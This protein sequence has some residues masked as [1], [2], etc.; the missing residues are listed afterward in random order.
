MFTNL[1]VAKQMVLRTAQELFNS[2]PVTDTVVAFTEDLD[3]A[4]EFAH[5]VKSLS[6]GASITKLRT[7]F[8]PLTRSY[9]YKS[10]K[11]V[12]NPWIP[13]SGIVLTPSKTKLSFHWS[14]RIFS[15]KIESNASRVAKH[16]GE[17]DIHQF[18]KSLCLKFKHFTINKRVPNSHDAHFELS[19]DAT[20]RE[21]VQAAKD[22]DAVRDTFDFWS[23][24]TISCVDIELEDKTGYYFNLED[25][26]IDKY[27]NDEVSSFDINDV[28]PEIDDLLFFLLFLVEDECSE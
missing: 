22:I 27:K 14:S 11:F 2:L 16:R 1:K 17:F 5:E 12:T 24:K 6:V 9:G 28:E 25:G 10:R 4:I 20:L 15:C 19:K 23:M 8:R 18:S 13:L 21:I 26:Q 3:K 7:T